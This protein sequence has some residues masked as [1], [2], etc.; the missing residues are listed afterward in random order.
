MVSFLQNSVQNVAQFV[1][2]EMVNVCKRSYWCNV[3][4]HRW[5]LVSSLKKRCVLVDELALS[6]IALLFLIQW[7][8]YCIMFTQTKK[9][10]EIVPGANPQL[11]ILRLCCGTVCDVARAQTVKQSRRLSRT[12]SQPSVCCCEQQTFSLVA[13]WQHVCRS[14][15]RDLLR[16]LLWL[17]PDTD[18][19]CTFA[20]DVAEMAGAGADLL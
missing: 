8:S 4:L 3:R 18:L 19:A 13:V 1:A 14:I 17:H 20:Y 5:Q 2:S 9:K 6:F 12:D 10:K 7:C 16:T 11:I 15:T